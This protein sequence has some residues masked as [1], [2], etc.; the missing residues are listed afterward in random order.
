MADANKQDTKVI[1]GE[2][3]LSFVHA[4][5]P[6]AFEDNEPK[7]SVMILIPKSDKKT[8]TKIQ[9]AVKAAIDNGVASKWGGKK[10]KNLALPLRDGDE[11]DFEGEEFE[12]CYFMRVASKTKPGIVDKDLEE[13]IDSNQIYS[14]CYARVSMNM[15]PYDRAGNRG[16]SA[17]LNNI[18]VL[19]DG[20]PLG[21][22]SRA[23]DDFNDD[24]MD[25]YDDGED[26]EGLDDLLGL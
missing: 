18:Q 1:T 23:E 10:P 12:S 8:L 21:G 25:N 22:R 15:F 4:L 3:R 16:V 19:R 11:E 5:E 14:G 7:Y 9:K 20:I 2:V 26:D 13:I 24:F 6:D 17:G